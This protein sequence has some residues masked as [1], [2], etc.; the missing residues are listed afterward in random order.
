MRIFYEFQYFER[1][2]SRIC[3]DIFCKTRKMSTKHQQLIGLEDVDNNNNNNNDVNCHNLNLNI[4][5]SPP[6]PPK[7][8]APINLDAQFVGD[9]LFRT[10]VTRDTID[11]MFKRSNSNF[12]LI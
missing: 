9:D 12:T 7:K 5:L 6:P 2:Y 1:S 3:S 4:T 8:R 11:H 10:L